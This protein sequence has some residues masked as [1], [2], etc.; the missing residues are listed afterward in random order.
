MMKANA[1]W[2]KNQCNYKASGDNY[3][4]CVYKCIKNKNCSWESC[5]EECVNCKENC[6]WI[7]KQMK[8]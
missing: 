1:E 4:D 8:I 3:T 6:P 7:Q 2:L 5:V